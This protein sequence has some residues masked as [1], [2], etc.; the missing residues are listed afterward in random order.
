M[1][2]GELVI[3]PGQD[4]VLNAGKAV[5]GLDVTSACDRPIQIGSHYNFLE[6]NKYLS[7]DRGQAY[8]KRLVI[9]ISAI[10]FTYAKRVLNLKPFLCCAVI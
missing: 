6:A 7:F 3:H 2:P 5:T 1:R 8:G 10:A 9:Y 4:I